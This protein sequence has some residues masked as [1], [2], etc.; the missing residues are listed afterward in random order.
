MKTYT[1]EEIDTLI[2]EGH[3]GDYYIVIHTHDLIKIAHAVAYNAQSGTPNTLTAL[4]EQWKMSIDK[5]LIKVFS[6]YLKQEKIYIIKNK[7]E[8]DA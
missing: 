6:T 7:N 3:T 2:A 1:K 5:H 4:T 8:E